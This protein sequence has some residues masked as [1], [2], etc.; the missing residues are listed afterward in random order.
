MIELSSAFDMVGAGGC[1]D[2]ASSLVGQGTDLSM[3]IPIYE[4]FYLKILVGNDSGFLACSIQEYNAL[5]KLAETC[6]SVTVTI[7]LL[8]MDL[9]TLIGA[10]LIYT[11]NT[12]PNIFIKLG[13]ILNN[14]ELPE[15]ILRMLSDLAG[16]P[17]PDAALRSST[18]Q[19]RFALELLQVLFNKLVE[20]MQQDMSMKGIEVHKWEEL[21]EYFNMLQNSGEMA[22]MAEIRQQLGGIVL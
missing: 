12:G 15:D 21:P 1:T 5:R 3:S 18:M 4:V 17:I 7:N 6:G 9:L 16:I 13:D 19:T 10:I 14:P 22:R 2:V 8:D 11:P 20:A